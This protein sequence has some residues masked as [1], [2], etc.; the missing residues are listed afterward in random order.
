MKHAYSTLVIFPLSLVTWIGVFWF[1]FV[2]Y[3]S[4]VAGLIGVAGLLTVL[5]TVLHILHR[6]L[7]FA[8]ASLGIST[9]MFDMLAD[10]PRAVIAIIYLMI[11]LGISIAVIVLYFALVISEL[12]WGCVFLWSHAVRT[13][14][15]ACQHTNSG[16]CAG[17]QDQVP[18]PAYRSRSACVMGS[19][20]DGRGDPIHDDWR[21]TRR[22]H[23]R[24]AQRGRERTECSKKG[25]SGLLWLYFSRRCRS[26]SKA[27]SRC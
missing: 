7:R 1:Q 3:V 18:L 10:R 23:G 5:L 24:G 14:Y 15:R 12:C 26:K 16:D 4:I 9:A 19:G 17:Q 25:D 11:S 13:G 20:Y 6:V 21:R 27:N 2:P 8:L 22:V